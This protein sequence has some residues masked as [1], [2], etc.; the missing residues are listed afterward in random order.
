MYIMSLRG[1]S[2]LHAL[3]QEL[4]TGPAPHYPDRRPADT[5][6]SSRGRRDR[7]TRATGSIEWA[8]QSFFAADTSTHTTPLL[9]SWSAITVSE[10]AL[11]SSTTVPP[12]ARAA[13]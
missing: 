11:L 7:R 3:H 13:A 2:A 5:S 4:S 12:A 9:P 6:A 8:F 1:S 10:G